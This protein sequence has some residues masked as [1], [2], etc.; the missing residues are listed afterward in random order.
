MA[1]GDT[2]RAAMEQRRPKHLVLIL[3]REFA[4][5]LAMPMLISDA[6]GNLVFF[7]EPAGGVLGRSFGQVGEL[8]A[9]RWAE[10]FETEELDGT[11]VPLERM[12]AGIALMEARP[13][14]HRF[15]IKGL[16]AVRRVISVTAFPLLAH[17]DDV[18]GV[19]AIF[20][21]ETAGDAERT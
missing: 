18:V 9:S 10:L 11:P 14:H 7:N 17:K 12:P 16:D 1:F 15:V 19:V 8:P 4:S 3:A 21:E 20:W 2:L 13:A 5:K 6:D